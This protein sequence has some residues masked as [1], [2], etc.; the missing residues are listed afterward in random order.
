MATSQF[1]RTE[2]P[3]LIQEAFTMEEHLNR[4]QQI[5]DAEILPKLTEIELD[6]E[7]LEL[8]RTPN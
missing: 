7:M 2:L 8:S 5:A 6:T 3:A 4:L 1:K